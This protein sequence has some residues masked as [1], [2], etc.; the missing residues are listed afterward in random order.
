MTNALVYLLASPSRVADTSWIRPGK[1]AWDWWNANNVHGVDFKSGV[2]T[3]TYKYYIDFASRYGLEYVILDEGWYKLGDLL[4]VVPEIDVARARRLREGEERR[5]HPWVVCEDA[6]RP[7]RC[8]RMEQFERW[9]VKGLKVDFMQ[10]DD[11][12]MM[13]FYHRVCREAAQ[14]KL[15]VD[16]H[17]AHAPGAADP[18]LAQP[19]Q[20]RG[21]PRPGAAQVERQVGPRAQRDAALHAHV[22]GPLRLH[23]R[24]DA[25]RL[26]PELRPGLRAADEPRHALPAAR[27]VRGVREPAADAGRLARRATSREP[28]SMEFLGPVPSVWDETRVLRREARRLRARRPPQ[29]PRVVGRRHDRRQPAR[30]RA[31]PRLPARGRLPR[32]RSYEDGP[33]AERWASDYRKTAQDVTRA[34]RLTLRLAGGGGF[35]ARIVPAP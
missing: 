27:D 24:G 11:Q 13:D 2:N 21:R 14:R 28:E 10:R 32:R 9:G 17:G 12:K 19:A 8:P 26:A 4:S 18:H 16:F 25:Q 7:V 29:R 34:T 3:A 20:H 30:A 23:A 22:R 31:R 5:D 33:N 6:R 15:L 1:V 35:A